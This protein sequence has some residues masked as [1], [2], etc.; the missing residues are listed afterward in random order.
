MSDQDVLGAMVPHNEPRIQACLI[1]A[2]VK[3]AQQALA[4]LAELHSPENSR[5]QYTA[6]R[7]DFEHR[8]QTR[9]TPCGQQIDNAGSRRPNGNV[10]VRHVRRYNRVG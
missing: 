4:V 2:K 3:S 5:E 7:R 10:Q 8:D 9:N 1:S 6:T